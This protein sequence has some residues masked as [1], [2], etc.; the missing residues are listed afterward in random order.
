MDLETDQ[1]ALIIG[2][3][4]VI[5]VIIFLFTQSRNTKPIPAPAPNPVPSPTFSFMPPVQSFKLLTFKNTG[6]STMLLTIET[7]VVLFV[8]D[9]NVFD[10]TKAVFQRFSQTYASYYTSFEMN[11]SLPEAS[12]LI[13]MLN[14]QST[15]APAVVIYEIGM[16]VGVRTIISENVLAATVKSSS[17]LRSPVFA[18]TA[19]DV[20][21]S[22]N[23]V[24]TPGKALL[25]IYD[26]PC[27]KCD[28]ESVV[29]QAFASLTKTVKV[30]S[31]SKSDPTFAVYS[32]KVGSFP[33]YLAYSEGKIDPNFK[34][35]TTVSIEAI[36]SQLNAQA[37]LP[38]DF[39]FSAPASGIVDITRWSATNT[40][41]SS[42][43]SLPTII[44]VY[45]SNTRKE[46][47]IA[48]Q[49]FAS[50]NPSIAN[51]ETLNTAIPNQ[52]NF[53]SMSKYP[54]PK[55]LPVAIK[56]DILGMPS[57]DF[58]RDFSTAGLLPLTTFNFD[59]KSVGQENFLI[60][61]TNTA[62]SSFVLTA[63]VVVFVYN[64][65]CNCE[66]KKRVY[67]KV[68]NKTQSQQMYVA[69]SSSAATAAFFSQTKLSPTTV[70]IHKWLKTSGTY[71]QDPI[72]S[73]FDE[74]T[75]TAY[76]A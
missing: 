30:Y 50:L 70:A 11:R 54:I 8:Y 24:N 10:E 49:T 69:N 6:T 56:F 46:S 5:V 32:Q 27:Q 20:D 73:A 29:V 48:F 51:Y 41:L 67:Q 63:P 33:Y 36:V 59:I 76:M 43:P 22:A 28:A 15:K 34:T 18:L 44:F 75:V 64:D 42:T 25:F 72:L 21:A 45:D 3:I 14:L 35:P 2:G 53:F 1:V 68:F 17:S 9:N 65:Y 23:L 55:P 57:K 40:F 71:S 58:S 13:S 4:I 66:A 61:G 52:Y 16:Q 38:Q 26:S 37:P 19:S 39:V 7:P 12:S 60:T 47:K 62:A 74:A 31:L